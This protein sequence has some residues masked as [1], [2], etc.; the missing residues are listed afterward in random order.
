MNKTLLIGRLLSVL[1]FFLFIVSCSQVPI[2]PP[3]DAI[4]SDGDVDAAS[5]SVASSQVAVEGFDGTV[6]PEGQTLENFNPEDELSSQAVLANTTGF[7]VYVRNDPASTQPWQIYRYDQAGNKSLKVFEGTRE[8]QSVA[9]SGDGNTVLATMRATTTAGSPFDVFRFVITPKVTTQLTNTTTDEKDV[10]ISADG[11]I[12]VWQGV[13]SSRATVFVR[14]YTGTTF[15]Q[16]FLNVTAPQVQPSVSGDGSF[17]ALIRQITS[18]NSYRVLTFKRSDGTYTTITSSTTL[19]ENP[20]VS[21]GG[22][23]VVW[24]QNAVTDI[25]RLKDIAANTTTNIVSSTAGLE[26]PFITATGKHLTYSQFVNNTW[27][28]RVRDLSTN[29]VTSST[30]SVSPITNK[31]AYWQDVG[32]YIEPGIV[33]ADWNTV[34]G[35]MSELPSSMR[36][37]VIFL[38]SQNKTLA[39]KLWMK[40]Q[41]PAL[42]SRPDKTYVD[43]TGRQFIPPARPTFPQISTLQAQLA[44]GD[45]GTGARYA[46]WTPVGLAPTASNPVGIR[47]YAYARAQIY[48]PASNQ[49]NLVLKKPNSATEFAEQPYAYYGDRSTNAQGQFATELDIGFQYDPYVK[50][51]AI[52]SQKYSYGL[53][54]TFWWSSVRYGADQL[55]TV[56]FFVLRD[57]VVCLNVIGQP[58]DA[59]QQLP[60][61]VSASSPGG[62]GNIVWCIYAEGWKKTGQGNAIKRET[63]LAQLSQRDSNNNVLPSSISHGASVLGDGIIYSGIEWQGPVLGS[64]IVD[65]G[66]GSTSARGLHRW[67]QFTTDT[68]RIIKFPSDPNK[69]LVEIFDGL[70][71]ERIEF[72]LS[73]TP[74]PRPF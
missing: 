15:T 10:S 1:G 54:Q 8:I 31:G 49:I 22:T 64:E 40:S 46:V 20:S 69:L 17:I 67:G 16:S 3:T 68:N 33:G 74:C 66:N 26:H 14:Q 29:T 32:F 70:G 52:F 5:R 43:S 37:N 65:L 6:L 57:S 28:V 58:I 4:F 41:L 7:I 2:Y 59:T 25:I 12:M 24:L 51:W 35:L 38:D 18:T 53:N 62:N 11:L 45:D 30:G 63:T 60:S 71:S 9:I 13:N 55:L 47:S 21:N 23:K 44:E 42:S 73:N 72:C 39:N 36:T 48:L 34:S 27:N 19:L 56:T 61:Y 50:N